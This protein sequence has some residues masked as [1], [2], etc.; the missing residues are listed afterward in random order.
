MIYIVVSGNTVDSIAER[1]SLSPDSVSFINQF[2][3][4]YRLT[5]GQALLLTDITEF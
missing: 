3:Y 4:P 1:Y 5:P 2:P